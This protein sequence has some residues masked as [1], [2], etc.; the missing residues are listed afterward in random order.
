[1]AKDL[2]APAQGIFAV[3]PSDSAYFS[4]LARSLYIGVEGNISVVAEDG[5]NAIFVGVP[6]GTVLP[7]RC[8]RV[9][10]TGT[11]ATDIVGL[12]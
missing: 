5:S 10:A 3:T 2:S 9:N 11:T 7:V 6:A 8:K 4:D 12:K 1:M